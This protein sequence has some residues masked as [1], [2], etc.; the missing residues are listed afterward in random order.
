MCFQNDDLHGLVRSGLATYVSQVC[1]GPVTYVGHFVFL[2]FQKQD[3]HVFAGP[4]QTARF[5]NLN[6]FSGEP[7]FTKTGLAIR[8]NELGLLPAMTDF[9]SDGF[10]VRQGGVC[11]YFRRD[12]VCVCFQKLDRHMLVCAVPATYVSLILCLCF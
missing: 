5:S 2:L 11:L 9:G 3:L 8:M 7:S 1:A 6:A 10:C 4:A 12:G